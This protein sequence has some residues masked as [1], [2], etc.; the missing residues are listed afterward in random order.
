MTDRPTQGEAPGVV[1]GYGEADAEAASMARAA[2]KD[3]R[4]G[5]AA[6]SEAER[7][8]SDAAAKVPPAGSGRVGHGT[9]ETD[10]KENLAETARRKAAEASRAKDGH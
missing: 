7:A 8:A 4:R 6:A 9:S 10:V 5:P 2:R 1:P 3:E